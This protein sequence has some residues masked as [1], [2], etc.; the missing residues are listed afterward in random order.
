[1][2]SELQS[3]INEMEASVS[4]ALS[5]GPVVNIPED[6]ARLTRM[7]KKQFEKIYHPDEYECQVKATITD[8]ETR[9]IKVHIA[10][11]PKQIKIEGVIK[12]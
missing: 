1:M 10:V 5:G 2:A 11:T 7:I 3:T 6:Q 12:L 8:P 4:K 9:Q